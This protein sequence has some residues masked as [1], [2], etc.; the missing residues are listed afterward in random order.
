MIT[1]LHS[2]TLRIEIVNPPFLSFVLCTL[3]MVSFLCGC[4][5][6]RKDSDQEGIAV[7]EEE[8]ELESE[9]RSG[10]ECEI[11]SDYSD[12]SINPILAVTLGLI[13]GCLGF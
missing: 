7:L 3:C 2:V 6:R 11:N 9:P 4:T 13:P 12:L 5:K 1:I 8:G 10:R